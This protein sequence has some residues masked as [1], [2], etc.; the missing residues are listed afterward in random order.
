MKMRWNLLRGLGLSISVFFGALNLASW[1]AAQT[2]VAPP[3]SGTQKH[4]ALEN[5]RQA[6]KLLVEADHDYDGHRARAAEEVRK[7]I[8]EL[9]GKQ[10]A[11]KVRTG[12]TPA[13]TVKPAKVKQP[14]MLEPQATSDTQLQQALQLLQA[15][16]PE[17]NSK[18]P[19]AEA[20]VAKA[21]QE[22][23]I[24]LKIK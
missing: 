12:A 13:V 17:V 22:L 1:S 5:L 4:A 15:A 8:R 7:A 23:T 3:A 2:T 16:V 18:H 19:K 20:N 9:E 10:R 21:I 14:A 11:K 6:H 24:A